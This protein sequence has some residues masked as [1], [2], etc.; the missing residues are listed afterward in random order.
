MNKLN[1]LAAF[2]LLTSVGAGSSPHLAMELLMA[3][4]GTQMIHVP[5]KGTAAPRADLAT[6]HADIARLRACLN[7]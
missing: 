4:T 7:N 5:Y 6:R 1:T 3:S 2:A